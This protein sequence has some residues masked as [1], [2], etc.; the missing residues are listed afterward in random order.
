MIKLRPRWFRFYR[1]QKGNAKL[2]G[3]PFLL[4][5]EDWWSIWKASGHFNERGRCSHQYCMAR[6]GD[7][8]AYEVGNVEIV[9]TNYNNTNG[10]AQR[11]HTEATKR[12]MKEIHKGIQY[13]PHKLTPQQAK[14]ARDL[15][16][17]GSHVL[18][19]AKRFGVSKSTVYRSVARAGQTS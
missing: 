18:V 13:C 1:Q 16:A 15:L 12:K 10:S 17:S 3:I 5:A 14:L 11:R 2:R 7:R 9:T 19:I 6:F 4:S 8:G